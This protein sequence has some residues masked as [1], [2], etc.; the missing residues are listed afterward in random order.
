V[1]TVCDSGIAG[2][3]EE[4]LSVP[5]TSVVYGT[6]EAA[7]NFWVRKNNGKE[8]LPY[9]A[10]S[11]RVEFD[12]TDRAIRSVNVVTADGVSKASFARIR[13]S[14]TL[15]HVCAKVADQTALIKKYMF[16]GSRNPV[17]SIPD[18]LFDGE[19]WVFPIECDSPEDNSDLEAEEET[20]RVVRTTLLFTVK[21]VAV[22]FDNTGD[23][24][25]YSQ[26]TSI[27][28]RI[29]CYDGFSTNNSVVVATLDVN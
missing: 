4:Q 1:I 17:I 23:G 8:V 5:A 11:R 29:H 12:D 10:F 26:I 28:A 2:V 13:V 18:T 15:E 24:T 3:I 25:E 20:G 6:L 19:D 14:Y 9:M 27:L 21:T 7:R 22:E 16:W